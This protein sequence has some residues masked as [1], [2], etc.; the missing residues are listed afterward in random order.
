MKSARAVARKVRVKEHRLVRLPDLR[1]AED[2]PRF[3]FGSLPSTYVPLRNSIFYSFAASYAEE[4][5]AGLIVGGHNKDDE[6]V[7]DDVS[8][9]FFDSLE[10]ALWA[11]S[12]TLRKNRVRIVRPL[13]KLDKAQ[14]VG[15][16]AST[17][18]PLGLTWSCH[19]D[20]DEHCWKCN[21]C[22]SRTRAFMGAGVKDPLRGGP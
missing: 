8:P 11:G 21:G 15:L 16:A 1:E 13:R 6:K 18:V 12:A 3:D 9:A 14:V 4:T 10:I 22:I 19:R 7:F 5:S 20:G 2:I 17:G